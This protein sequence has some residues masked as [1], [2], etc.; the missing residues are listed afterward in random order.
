VIFTR[1]NLSNERLFIL[2]SCI[3]WGFL[4]IFGGITGQQQR[5]SYAGQGLFLVIGYV[6]GKKHGK[7]EKNQTDYF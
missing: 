5:I 2:N 1:L 6:L 4:T 7:L 3:V